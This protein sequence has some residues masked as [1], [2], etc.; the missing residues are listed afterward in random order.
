[1][2]IKERDFKTTPFNSGALPKMIL[3]YLSSRKNDTWICGG[4]LRSIFLGEKPRDYDVFFKNEDAYYAI[5]S[6]LLYSNHIQIDEK[7]N[8]SIIHFNDFTIELIH[9]K[10]WDTLEDCLSSFDIT[11]CMAGT[12]G[13]EYVK[14]YSFESDNENKRIVIYNSTYPN[15][16]LFRIAKYANKGYTITPNE[17]FGFTE[18]YYVLKDGYTNEVLLGSAA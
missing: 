5:K 18:K 14:H 7:T 13:I 9:S 15:S 6:Y 4:A 1:M 16:T 2:D 8:S 11:L 12:D 3:A 10:Y 17:V